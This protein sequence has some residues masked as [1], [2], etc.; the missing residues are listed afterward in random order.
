MG[1][2]K[3]ISFEM[4]EA[5]GISMPTTLKEVLLTRSDLITLSQQAHDACL[6]P[7]DPGGISYT[8]RA[9]LAGRIAMLHEECGLADYYKAMIPTDDSATNIVDPSIALSCSKAVEAMIKHADIVTTDPKN[10]GPKSIRTL[11]SAGV[12][13]TDL[14]RLSEIIAFMNYAIRVLKGIRLMG[15]I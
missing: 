6:R 9:A 2:Q 4:I 11:E 5:A 1:T 3:S 15:E 7:N 12:S 14:V 10:V 8:N 13:T